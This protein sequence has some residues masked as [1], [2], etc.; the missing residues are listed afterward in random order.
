MWG[1]IGLVCLGAVTIGVSRLKPAAPEVERS[2][3]WT[4]T[5]KRGPMLRQ[6]R[7]LGSLIPSQEFTRQIPAE[8][9]ATVVRILK[10]P[11][12]QVKADTILLEMSNPQVEQAAVDAKLQLKAAE[13]EYQSLRVTLQEQSDEPKSGRPTRNPFIRRQSRRRRRTAQTDAGC[14]RMNGLLQDIRYALRQ[15]RKNPG[16][17][18]VAVLTLALGIG[19]TTA[20]YSIVDSLLF[21]PLPYPNSPRIVRIWNTF[22]PRGMMEIPASEPEFLEYR[23]SHTF[24]HFAGFS[25]GALTLTGSGDP[26]RVAATWGT[27]DFFQVMGTNP[28]LG[29]GFTSD[30]FEPGHS[31]VAVIS[32][33]LWQDHFGSNPEIIGRPIL[34]NGQS[35]TVVGVMPHNFNFPSNDVA[36]WQPLQIQPASTNLGN[37]Y[38]NLIGDLK[39]QVTPERAASEM[40]MLLARI[41]RNY[42]TYYAGAVGIGVS[43]IPLRQ[44]MVGNLRRIVL[45]LM[46]G[47]GFMLVIACTNV[48]SLL[49]A[50]GEDRWRELA[51][52]AALGATRIRILNQVLIENLLLFSMG[53][54]I[55]LSF[56]FAAMK[57]VSVGNYF[58]IA[59]L[60]G[61][62]LDLR[63]LAFTAIVSLGTGLFFGFIPALKATRSN[64][65]DVL[66]TGGRERVASRQQTRTRGLLVTTE[67]AFSLVLLTGA[68]LMM[69]SLVKLLDVSLGFNPENVVT[70]RL[71]LPQARY[72]LRQ[73]EA[74]FRQLQGRVRGLPGVQEAAIANQLPMGDVAA[75]A[76]FD[77]EGRPVR[78]DINVADTQIISPGYFQVMGISLISGSFF[79]DTDTNLPPASVIVNQTLARKV[80]PGTDPIG[81]RIRLRPDAPWLSVVG[82]VA[83]IKNHGSNAAT[84]PE[85]YFLHTDQPFGIW[86]DL[87][88]V[89]LVLRTAVEPQQIVGAVR[90]QLRNLDPELPIFKVSTLEEVVA[91]SVSQTRFPTMA[92][93]FFA[94]IALFL[95]AVGVYGVL[96][97]TVAQSRHDIG[98]RLALGARRGQI[99]RFFLSQRVQ[100]AAIG[101]FAGITAALILV[102]FMRGMLFEVSAYD[103][104]IFFAVAAVLSLVVLM[105][106]IIPALRATKVDP[107]VA[108]RYE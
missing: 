40:A 25:T 7:G 68:G 93:S 11:G 28:L 105:A 85:M 12:S 95:S 49:L 41:E 17:T 87:R 75:D 27:S 90:G 3:V 4:D 73:A 64:V 71:S 10:L 67:I 83:D 63:L 48:A 6:V 74:F 38:L 101:G 50:R 65:S 108:L 107:M 52:R 94:G 98:V 92:L 100:W 46:V 66:K 18:M 8:T 59:Q 88:S 24:A 56:A 76:S 81:K 45:V 21:R 62:R 9:E 61:V 103:P 42:P 80:W 35:S 47:V 78:T 55:G 77:V 82:V 33:G 43:L 39:Q 20:I 89:T 23:Q 54:V 72:S 96:A 60:G 2:T 13:A 51:T 53:G 16:F 104:E 86:A 5:V 99:L 30:E 31:Q 29:R 69:E 22:A 97:Y 36:V 44:Q 14:A 1:A 34:L 79:S 91:S 84:K 102:R 58:D 37:H 26:L 32:Y 15:L 70:M 19:A 57:F 106:S